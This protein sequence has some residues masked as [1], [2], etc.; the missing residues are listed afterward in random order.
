MQKQSLGDLALTSALDELYGLGYDYAE[1]L[2]AAY[3]SVTP[4]QVQAAAQ[5]YLGQPAITSIVKPA[6]K[7]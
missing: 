6:D 1:K 3:G 4:A 2:I 7:Q 5:K